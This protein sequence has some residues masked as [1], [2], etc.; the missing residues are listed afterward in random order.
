MPTT[1]KHIPHTPRPAKR[2]F[3]AA[4]FTGSITLLGIFTAC[5]PPAPTPRAESGVLDLRAWKN[6]GEPVALRGQWRFHWKSFQPG[7]DSPPASQAHAPAAA[8]A[9]DFLTVPGNWKGRDFRIDG[10]TVKADADGFGLYSLKVLLPPEL[11]GKRLGLKIPEISTAFELEIN[12]D[13]LASA[14]RLGKTRAEAKPDFRS[15]T[16]AFRARGDELNIRVRVSN[17]H[18]RAGGL[19]KV[20]LLGTEDAIQARRTRNLFFDFLLVGGLLIMGLYHVALFINR[21]EDVPSLFFGLVCLLVAFRTLFT[22]EHAISILMPDISW[23]WR[24]KLEYLTFYGGTAV[25]QVFFAL[26]YGGK[27]RTPAIVFISVACGL[28]SLHVLFTPV[29]VFTSYLIFAQMLPLLVF[30]YS[31]TL[32]ILAM[33]R[34]KK[35]ATMAF[36]GGLILGATTVNDILSTQGVIHTPQMGS[37]GLFLFIFVQAAL[38][39]RI[40][41]GAFAAVR[42]LTE[43]LTRT[44]Q[45][46]SRFVPREFLDQLHKDDITEIELGDQV[47]ME[48]SV[49]FTDIRAFTELSETMSPQEN[50]NF[51]NSYLKRMTPIVREMGGFVDKYIGDSIMALFPE[52]PENAIRTAI[53]MQKEIQVYNEHRLQNGYRPIAAGAGIHTGMLM[54]GT[55]GAAERMEGTVISDTVNLA[56]RIEQLT[57]AYGASIIISSDALEKMPEGTFRTRFLDHVRVKGKQI[58]STVYQILDGLPE[59]EIEMYTKTEERYNDAVKDFHAGRL[60]QARERFQAILNEFPTNKAAELFIKRCDRKAFMR[61]RKES[62]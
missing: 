32:V 55:I 27:T 6:H 2:L 54:L 25:I 56:A 14:G 8:S 26:L 16:R 35:G 5:A 46:Y 29:R 40:F 17:H 3:A 47:Q 34:G 50:F 9:A 21:R 30:F 12:G 4:I 13:V 49:L 24:L 11:K 44:N 57:K 28:L 60:D 58:H 41:A 22:G 62:N 38:L 10:Q 42:S 39:S 20:L 31:M 48:M 36:A 23:A 53:L 1:R 33:I 45:A 7:P 37:V 19:R 15:L 51:L 59:S 52:S 18:H 43:M 61:R